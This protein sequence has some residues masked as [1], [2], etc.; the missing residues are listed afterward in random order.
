[1]DDRVIKVTARIM[2][3][4]YTIRGRVSEEHILRIARFVDEKMLQISEA[5]PKLGTSRIAVLTALNLADEL[6]K[7]RD[8]YDQLTRLLEEEWSQRHGSGAAEAGGRG[9]RGPGRLPAVAAET[10]AGADRVRA[11]G[12]SADADRTRSG[13]APAGPGRTQAPSAVAGP[14]GQVQLAAFREFPSDPGPSAGAGPARAPGD[15]GTPAGPER[16]GAPAA[17]GGV[18]EAPAA[19]EGDFGAAAP[20]GGGLG[21]PK[22]GGPDLYTG[23]ALAASPQPSAPPEPPRTSGPGARFQ[24]GPSWEPP[25]DEDQ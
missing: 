13:G 24:P 10:A 25:E 11:A 21:Q 2:G 7:I 20:P 1:M 14:S 15:P 19:R 17:P 22:V 18:F 23:D 3:E 4:E 6:L 5:Y 9:G 12:T 8:Q 16:G